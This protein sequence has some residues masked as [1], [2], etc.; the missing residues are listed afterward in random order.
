MLKI[1]VAHKNENIELA[2]LVIWILAELK[3]L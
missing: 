1:R 3:Y 2:T